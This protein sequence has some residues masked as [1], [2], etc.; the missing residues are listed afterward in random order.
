[1]FDPHRFCQT[2]RLLILLER[3]ETEICFSLANG[4]LKMKMVI[5]SHGPKLMP[6]NC[7]HLD[8]AYF[9]FPTTFNEE[10]TDWPVRHFVKTLFQAVTICA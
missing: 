3:A 1:M 4:M 2:N 8:P 9:S 6:N 7:Q 5:D 10:K